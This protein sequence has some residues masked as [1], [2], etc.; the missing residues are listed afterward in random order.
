VLG[1]FT[2]F[3]FAFRS[4]FLVFHI[5]S[6]F[7]CHRIWFFADIYQV[8]WTFSWF[9]FFPVFSSYWAWCILLESTSWQEVFSFLFKVFYISCCWL[10]VF[11]LLCSDNA[12]LVLACLLDWIDRLKSNGWAI[13]Q[14]F[15]LLSA[16]Q[17]R[18]K[19]VVNISSRMCWVGFVVLRDQKSNGAES[20]KPKAEKKEG[21]IITLNESERR[22]CSGLA[23]CAVLSLYL[24]TGILSIISI[25]LLILSVCLPVLCLLVSALS[26]LST[27]SWFWTSI[28][29]SFFPTSF[30]FASL[31]LKP[32]SLSEK[33]KKNIFLFSSS[34]E[35]YIYTYL[36]VCL[37]VDGWVQR[38]RL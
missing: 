36:S 30:S 18:I 1:F 14:L 22:K 34:R 32:N 15:S 35:F 33:N 21:F 4:C 26:Y 29:L 13:P 27:G 12:V 20:E 19:S 17:Q 28:Y 37:L 8:F 16:D 10:G 3:I 11:P 5:L 23:T 6:A 24:S 31:P 38:E 25:L 7:C 9:A 2:I